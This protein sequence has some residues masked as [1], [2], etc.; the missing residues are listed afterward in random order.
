PWAAKLGSLGSAPE[1]SDDTSERFGR[2]P[3]GRTP[4]I[5]LNYTKASIGPLAWD[6][7]PNKDIEPNS[8]CKLTSNVSPNTW[9]MNWK[10]LVFYSVAGGFQPAAGPPACGLAP[11]NCLTVNP[12]SL[13]Q[14]KEV[15]VITAG[16]RLQTVASGQP[17]T[18]ADKAEIRN[19]LEGENATPLPPALPDD[20]FTVQ[21]A[22]TTFND[23]VC[24]QG[25][26]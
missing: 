25:I 2:L 15:V 3:D 10:E 9:W 14:D 21:A 26:C 4:G 17:R 11:N 5:T 16:K 13:A 7:W 12:P 1:Y 23:V 6:T 20:T 18:S 8:N 24:K 19:Y 22:S